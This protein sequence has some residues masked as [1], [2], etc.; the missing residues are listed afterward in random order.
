MTDVQPTTPGVWR[1][2]FSLYIG[3][4][5]FQQSDIL[6]TDEGVKKAAEIIVEALVV[7]DWR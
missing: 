3:H 1:M 4:T 6:M 2:I 5:I 7:E